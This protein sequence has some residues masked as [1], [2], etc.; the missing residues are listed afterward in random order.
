MT[1][2][3]DQIHTH[4]NPDCHVCGTRGEP[5]YQR[6]QDRLFSAPG[7]WDLKRCQDPRCGLVWLD[8]MPAEEDIEQFYETYYTHQDKA[9]PNNYLRGAYR[10]LAAG[11]TASRYGYRS[12]GGS[13]LDQ[14]LGRLIYLLPGRRADLD[15]RVFF[16]K[17]Q[18]GGRLLEVGCGGGAILNSLQKL[19]WA[20]EGL[21]FDPNSI[22]NA[23]AKGLK[24]HLG[25]LEQQEYPDNTFDV[26]VMS[27]V[28]EHVPDPL[29]L[30]R[31]CLRI[32]KL[33]G[34][35]VTITPNA[36]SWGHH[37]YGV[38]WRGLEPPRHLHIFTQKSLTKIALMA[39]F[40]KNKCWSVGRAR[41]ILLA[42]R[43]LHRTD[44]IMK[45]YPLS[46]RLWAEGMEL[47]E[48]LLLKMGRVEG[49]EIVL[50]CKK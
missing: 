31:E 32:V 42:S 25:G 46:M 14:I 19:G 41:A 28:I 9:P 4:S 22:R 11:Y 1:H 30:L 2:I 33:G 39:G 18:S 23:Q 27:H 26:I 24:V 10:R 47:I 6:L 20:T 17:S 40:E 15:A 21:D 13:R 29:A 35:V 50:V 34:K 45:R 48:W 37:L 16:L 44:G 38:D 36:N 3:N 7:K 49:E 8:P 43:S 12:N 5:L